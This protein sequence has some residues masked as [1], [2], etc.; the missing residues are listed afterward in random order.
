M[1]YELW[2]I[3]IE[4]G[5]SEPLL[6]LNKSCN[7]TQIYSLFLEVIKVKPCAILINMENK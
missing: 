2:E 6:L 5:H 1:I 4:E 3:I 7:F